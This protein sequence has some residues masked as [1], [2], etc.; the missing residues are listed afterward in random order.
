M[1]PACP[2]MRVDAADDDVVDGARIDVD[3]VEDAAE[4]V[5]AQVD[6]MHGGQ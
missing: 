5:H 6:R 4:R 1:L 3:P 2:P